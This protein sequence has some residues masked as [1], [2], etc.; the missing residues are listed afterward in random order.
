MD[1][2]PYITLLTKKK[3]E[4]SDIK[5]WYRI[6]KSFLPS[7]MLSSIQ[8]ADVENANAPILLVKEFEKDTQ[9]YSFKIP[10]T[11]NLLP[12]EVEPIADA[13]NDITGDSYDYTIIASTLFASI[14]QSEQ[15]KDDTFE[16]IAKN[17]ARY[18]H[19]QDMKKKLEN[20]WRYGVEDDYFEKI[21][22]TLLPFDSVGP[23]LQNI[24]IQL[25][26]EVIRELNENGYLVIKKGP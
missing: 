26:N 12:D 14:D 20:G 9:E 2:Y 15:V 4:N 1:N 17:I 13:Y 18:L 7:G 5:N 25:I 16:K 19:T 8:N 23:D 21:S 10:L 3:L 6:V 22:S 24:D 11:R